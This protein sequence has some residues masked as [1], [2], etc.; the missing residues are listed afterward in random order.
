MSRLISDNQGISKQTS[1]SYAEE[2]PTISKAVCLLFCN[3]TCSCDK[4]FRELFF[5]MSKWLYNDDIEICWVVIL[6]VSITFQVT[7]SQV[8]TSQVANVNAQKSVKDIK[9]KK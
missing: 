1:V 5:C 7:M 6:V 3:F 2:D 8:V 9:I 4:K